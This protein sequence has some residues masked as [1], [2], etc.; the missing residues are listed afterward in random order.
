MNNTA[1]KEHDC[2]IYNIYTSKHEDNQCLYDQGNE[3]QQCI[4]G[5]KVSQKSKTMSPNISNKGSTKV[6]EH[7]SF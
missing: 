7:C 4:I 3:H 6:C 5:I 1:S 2:V